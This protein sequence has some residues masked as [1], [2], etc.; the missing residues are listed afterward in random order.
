MTPTLTRPTGVP[1][2]AWATFLNLR[3]AGRNARITSD[4]YQQLQAL[5]RQYPV[6][7]EQW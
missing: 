5:I 6:L 3:D 2:E 4:D 1:A 7:Q